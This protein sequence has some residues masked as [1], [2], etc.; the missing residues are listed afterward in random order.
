MYCPL[1]PDPLEIRKIYTVSSFVKKTA[2]KLSI[3][4]TNCLGFLILRVLCFSNDAL[5][6]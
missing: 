3:L 6:R 2:N 1:S 5:S 4:K